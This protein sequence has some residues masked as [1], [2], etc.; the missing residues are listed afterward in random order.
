V[1]PA[2]RKRR[3]ENE[4]VYHQRRSH[5]DA[6]RSTIAIDQPLKIVVR[7]TLMGR[8]GLHTTVPTTFNS[9]RICRGTWFGNIRVVGAS[10]IEAGK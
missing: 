1:R 4:H 9:A 8:F 2:F 10:E 7:K 5:S 6:G 3:K